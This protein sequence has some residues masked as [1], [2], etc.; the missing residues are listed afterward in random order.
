[1]TM[2]F[3]GGFCLVLLSYL[4]KR[5]SD[6]E[7]RRFWSSSSA[8]SSFLPFQSDVPVGRDTSG[9]VK[10]QGYWQSFRRYLAPLFSPSC[11]FDSTRRHPLTHAISLNAH[12][13]GSELNFSCSRS[14]KK[15]R[16]KER[17]KRKRKKAAPSTIHRPFV[18]NYTSPTYD[19][20]SAS[21]SPSPFSPPL[22]FRLSLSF[23]PRLFN[24]C[25]SRGRRMRKENFLSLSSSRL[26]NLA[27]GKKS[28]D[29]K[30]ISGLYADVPIHRWLLFLIFLPVDDPLDRSR[31]YPRRFMG[32]YQRL[33][34]EIRD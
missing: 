18:K 22:F 7:S 16:K 24:L 11:I 23:S 14:E 15:E 6:R 19:F 1:M 17:Q 12:S 8:S 2:L 21:F 26:L 13:R 30:L 27:T 10:G 20:K 33:K 3:Y 9:H 32:P 28:P 25:E 29:W 5:D 34:S 4:A 31:N